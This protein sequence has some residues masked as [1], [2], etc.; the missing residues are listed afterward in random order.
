MKKKVV[1]ELKTYNGT[2]TTSIDE[3]ATSVQ[4]MGGIAFALVF[5]LII[6]FVI[7]GVYLSLKRYEI[8]S[9]AL[10]R[11]D[12]SIAA[13]ALAPEIGQGIGNIFGTS[14]HRY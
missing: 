10:K 9:Q 2:M 3:P 4:T 8:A 14:S 1:N 11:G 7:V 12:T 5:I 13:A 6:A